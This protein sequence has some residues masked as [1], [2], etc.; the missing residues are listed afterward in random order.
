MVSEMFSSYRPSDWRGLISEFLALEEKRQG[1]DIGKH[2]NG[3]SIAKQAN[4]KLH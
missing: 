1:S 4:G 3:K 2:V